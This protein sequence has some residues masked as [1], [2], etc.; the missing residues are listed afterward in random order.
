MTPNGSITVSKTNQE[1]AYQI[2]GK[3]G[4]NKFKDS[5]F[6]ENGNGSLSYKATCINCGTINILAKRED[7]Q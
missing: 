1:R 7:Q 6:E 4:H 2:C 5:F 3:C